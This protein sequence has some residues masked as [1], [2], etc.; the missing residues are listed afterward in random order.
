MPRQLGKKGVFDSQTRLSFEIFQDSK[1]E[2]RA[3]SVYYEKKG[4]RSTGG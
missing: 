1:G 3:P 2:S 4:S